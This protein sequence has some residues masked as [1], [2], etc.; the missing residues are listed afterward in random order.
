MEG[1]LEKVTDEELQLS[2]YQDTAQVD[3][4]CAERL[5]SWLSSILVNGPL[6]RQFSHSI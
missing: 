5:T 2:L 1:D 4:F 3:K 6:S